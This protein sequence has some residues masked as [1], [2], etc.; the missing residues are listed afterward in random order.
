MANTKPNSS[1]ITYMPSITVKD[2][3]D[4]LSS[5]SLDG[6]RWGQILTLTNSE[7]IQ[8]AIDSITDASIDKIYLIVLE[9]GTYTQ[10]FV[11]KDFVD[12]IGQSKEG[13]IITFS[14]D[15]DTVNISGVRTYL[16]NVQLFHTGASGTPRYALHS[17]G[18]GAGSPRS[19]TQKVF[20]LS[21]KKTGTVKQAIGVGIYGFQK[22]EF[23]NVDAESTTSNGIFMHNI[24][25]QSRQSLIQLNNVSSVSAAGFASLRLSNQGSGQSDIVAI[26][27]GEYPSGIECV[28]AGSGASEITVIKNKAVSAGITSV[29][30]VLTADVKYSGQSSFNDYL[31]SLVKISHNNATFTGGGSSFRFPL[32]LQYLSDSTTGVDF[33][34]TSSGIFELKAESGT[35]SFLADGSGYLYNT[36]LK[37]LNK[38]GSGYVNWASR[39][40][41]GA[42][43]YIDLTNIGDIV[44]NGVYKGYSNFQMP[45]KAGSGWLT[46]AARSTAGSDA[47]IVL[48]NIQKITAVRANF[49]A[50]PVFAT[51]EAAV[52]GGLGVGEVYRTSNNPSL[53]CVVY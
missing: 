19:S 7:S 44:V 13:V 17:D 42:A 53:L 8:S 6:R 25:G 34:V 32:R 2:V 20:N 11:G 26:I 21:A 16:G 45:N 18:G 37:F 15:A 22:I 48:S 30:N 38:T 52:V 24:A 41:A 49:S 14:G 10:S 29:G 28:N 35:T 36:G 4:N 50:I 27:G 39:N 31:Q 9:N 5:V 47:E 40:A 51:N 43:A 33:G 1:Q 46:W 12:V 3:L 23:D